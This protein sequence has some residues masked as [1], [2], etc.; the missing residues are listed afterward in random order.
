MK[1]GPKR[2]AAKL[3][4]RRRKRGKPSKRLF[5]Y[6]SP[7]SYAPGILPKGANNMSVATVL[8]VF[9]NSSL[10]TEQGEYKISRV[11]NDDTAARRARY[12]YHQTVNGT[13]IYTRRSRKGKSIYAVID[14][15]LVRH[16]ETGEADR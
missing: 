15:V 9:K 3:K 4:R 8:R 13:A 7:G 12:Q 14:Q 11:F 1:S 2:E 10:I 6:I 16:S 5:D